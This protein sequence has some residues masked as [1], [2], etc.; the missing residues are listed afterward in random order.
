MTDVGVD[1]LLS[2]VSARE[3]NAG[4]IQ[5]AYHIVGRNC[6]IDLI[7]NRNYRRRAAPRCDDSRAFLARFSAVPFDIIDTRRQARRWSDA[8]AAEGLITIGSRFDFHTTIEKLDQSIASNGMALL[9]RIDHAE[10]A[11]LAGL[12]LR[13]TVVLIFGNAKAGTPLMQA[14]RPIGI[15]LPLKILVW[16]DDDGQTKMTYTDVEW[17]AKRHAVP[18]GLFPIVQKMKH[19]LDEVLSSASES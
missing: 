4:R 14:S 13:P 15:D 9:A 3:R 12:P 5:Q 7:L 17:L 6:P 2:F 1:R 19:A 10:G 11:G 8:M 18:E 16:E